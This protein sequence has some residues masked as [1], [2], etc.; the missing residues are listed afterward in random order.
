MRY[1]IYAPQRIP[2]KVF[3]N[4]I[5]RPGDLVTIHPIVEDEV[6]DEPRQLDDV[7]LAP[8]RLG[9]IVAKLKLKKEDLFK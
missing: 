8:I 3:I 9:T 2:L 6:N 1:D 5:R 7:V 4:R